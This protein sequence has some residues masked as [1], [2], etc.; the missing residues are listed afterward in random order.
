GISRQPRDARP[1]ASCVRDHVIPLEEQAEIEDAQQ[2]QQHQWQYECKL[3]ELGSVLRR[4]STPPPRQRSHTVTTVPARI[5]VAYARR[6]P[7]PVASVNSAIGLTPASRQYAR[8]T[9]KLRTT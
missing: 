6:G 2:Q 1:L 5:D 3:D 9:H 8:S 7:L 4:P